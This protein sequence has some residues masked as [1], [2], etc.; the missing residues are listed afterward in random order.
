M[1]QSGAVISGFASEGAGSDETDDFLRKFIFLSVQQEKSE[2]VKEGISLERGE[3][4]SRDSEWLP[5]RPA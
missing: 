2:R 1:Y 5:T 3:W 4:E